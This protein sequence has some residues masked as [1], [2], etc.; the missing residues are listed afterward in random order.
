M[1]HRYSW[2]PACVTMWSLAG[3]CCWVIGLATTS[4]TFGLWGFS[5]MVLHYLCRITRNTL[6]EPH[7]PP[8][9]QVTR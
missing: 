4:A 8:P 7:L 1:R 2:P 9:Q 6:P 3:V 5:F